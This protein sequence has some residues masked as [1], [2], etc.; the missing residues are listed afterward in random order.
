MRRPAAKTGTSQ[1]GVLKPG[2][3]I[4]LALAL[5]VA[6]K[7]FVADLAVVEGRSML[8][9]L[10]QGQVVFVLRC[11]YGLRAPFRGDY[12]L[13]WASPEPGQVVAATS[14]RDGRPVVK[15]VAA[16]GASADSVYLLGDNAAESLDSRDYGPV[17]VESVAGRVLFWF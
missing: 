2:V 14:P 4:L 3:L 8:P 11:A 5:A 17:P 7:T 6:G 12:L 10:A 9:A 13:R 16:G 15:R 1:P